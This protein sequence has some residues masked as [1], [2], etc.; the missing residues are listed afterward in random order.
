MDSSD[1]SRNIRV[2]GP[3]GRTM[4]A[5]DLPSPE[6]KRWVSALKARVVAGVRGGLIGR[7]EACARYRLSV[8]ELLRW[9]TAIDRYGV[10]GLQATRCRQQRQ[11]VLAPETDTAERTAPH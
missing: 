1:P 9:Q 10:N 3:D 4:T 11:N 8:E 2:I 5:D 7:D 6:T